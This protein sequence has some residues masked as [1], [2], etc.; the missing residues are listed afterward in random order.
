MVAGVRPQEEVVWTRKTNAAWDVKEDRRQ[1]VVCNDRIC[2]GQF[3]CPSSLSIIIIMHTI[4]RGR[5]FG[6]KRAVQA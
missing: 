5:R 2:Q 3:K 1:V 4:Q 6:G